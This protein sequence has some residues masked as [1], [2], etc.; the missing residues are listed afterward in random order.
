LFFFFIDDPTTAD[1]EF[2]FST[3][4]SKVSTRSSHEG[5][6]AQKFSLSEDEDDDDDQPAGYTSLLV[7]SPLGRMH[8]SDFY[9]AAEEEEEERLTDLRSETLSG[10]FEDEEDQSRFDLDD[11]RSDNEG[12]KGSRKKNR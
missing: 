8:V 4:N 9:P 1:R 3:P 10:G 11:D 2:C 5:N 6:A 7:A 12:G